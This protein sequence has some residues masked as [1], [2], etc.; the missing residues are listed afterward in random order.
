MFVCLSIGL[1]ARLCP[2][3]LSL[4]PSLPPSLPQGDVWIFME[5][6]DM[7]LDKL[8]KLV[9]EKLSLTIPE[10]VVGKMAE[11]VRDHTLFSLAN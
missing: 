7:S 10:N 5:L 3:P 8:Y 6:M 9:Y 4:S 1:T 11:A 2:L